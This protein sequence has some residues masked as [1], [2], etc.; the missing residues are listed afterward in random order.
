NLEEKEMNNEKTNKKKALSREV[1]SYLIFGVLTTA[2]GWIVYFAVLLS[3]KAIFSVS[4]DPTNA[5]YIAIY[6]TAQIIQWI[7]AVLFAFFTNR[8]WVFTEADKSKK[9][10]P[11]LL[12]FSSGRVLTLLLDIVITFLGGLALSK[13]LP[14]LNSVTLLGFTFNFNEISAKLVA[15]VVVIVC[16]YIFSKLFVF[17]NKK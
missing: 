9:M 5:R 13:L 12:A 6:I 14:A 2:V 16:N 3:G 4:T 11:Q 15:A 8:K 1:V 7:C 10:L 17:K